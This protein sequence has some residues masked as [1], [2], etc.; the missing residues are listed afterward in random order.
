MASAPQASGPTEHEVVRDLGSEELERL[1]ERGHV[2][3][4]LERA[5]PQHVGAVADRPHR[6]RP[7]TRRR[8]VPVVVH[9]V[10]HDVGAGRI[11]AG[12][13]DGPSPCGLGHAD[14]LVGPG[15]A[16]RD[17]PLEEQPLAAL[18]HLG[19]GQ[20]RV[21][22]ERDGGRDP[23]AGRQR[24]VHAVEHVGPEAVD[25]PTVPGQPRPRGGSGGAGRG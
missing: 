14:H 17:G 6:R 3:P 13:L 24:V 15:D 18:V 11:C 2:L 25:P 4:R 19:H 20:H 21:V 16:G 1:H 5:D 23:E 9:G 22:V 8:P 10:G 12:V 7:L